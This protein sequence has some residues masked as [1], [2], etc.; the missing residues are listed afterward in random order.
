MI[1]TDVKVT[2]LEEPKG[3]LLAFASIVI[4]SSF[5][6]YGFKVIEGV[7]G[8]FV[9]MPNRKRNDGEFVEIAHPINKETRDAIS[10]AILSAYEEQ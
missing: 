1:I 8:T 3:S 5:V 6:V 9:A 7:N 4:D 10:T 2:K